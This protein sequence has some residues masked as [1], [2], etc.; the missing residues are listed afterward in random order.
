MIGINQSDLCQLKDVDLY[1]VCEDIA[2]FGFKSVR[3][4]VDW[5]YHSNF[6]GVTDY[7]PARRVAKALN[8]FRLE[9]LPVLGIHYPFISPAS[10]FGNHVAKVVDIFGDCDYYEVWN[11]P[12]LIGFNVRGGVNGFMNYLA[13]ASPRIRNVGSQV[14]S[15]G[16]AAYPTFG[17]Y[18]KSPHWWYDEMQ[19]IEGDRNLY[20]LFGY[21]PYSINADQNATFADPR[22]NPFGI[23]QLSI[24]Q[25]LMAIDG[26]TRPIA[27]TEVGYVTTI[28]NLVS[29]MDNLAYQLD[30]MRK[31]DMPTWVFCWRDTPGDGGTFGFVDKYNQP[32]GIYYEWMKS[33]VNAR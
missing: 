9:P 31:Y 19:S 15:G 6:L 23:E 16:L 29:C 5:G 25:D 11:E 24:L 17:P 22:T 18:N 10:G 3:F 21:H 8:E 1:S 32:K 7:N 2:E 14:I 4:A 28:S 13:A 12:N 26:N 20:D 33:L 30:S 27:I